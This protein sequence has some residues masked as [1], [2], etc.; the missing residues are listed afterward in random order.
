MC[1]CVCVCV[2]LCALLLLLLSHSVVSDFAIPGTVVHQAPVSMTFPWQEYCS[3]L[4]IP[5]S[6]YLPYPG[7]EPT[8]PVS[9]VLAGSLPLSHLGR[10]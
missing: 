10:L 5:P 4:A 9:P 2:C 8:S 6:G 3:G 7:I 1:V